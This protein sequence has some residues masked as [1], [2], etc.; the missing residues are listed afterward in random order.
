MQAHG[1]PLSP[2]KM[3]THILSAALLAALNIPATADVAPKDAYKAMLNVFAYDSQGKLLHSGAAFFTDAQGNAVTSYQMLQGASRAEV[4]DFKGK[5]YP[6]SRIL[7][8]NATTDLAK[9]SIEGYKGNEYFAI[10]GQ[11]A[12]KD[13]KL[14]LVRYTTD[15]KKLP[16]AVSI[17]SDEAYNAF[18]YYYVDAANE[19]ADMACPLIDETGSIVGIL[20]RNVKK[21]ASSAC[22]IDARFVH[23]LSIDATAAF[24]SDLR[25]IYIPKALPG[26]AKDALTYLYM[27]PASDSLACLTAYN[28]FVAAYPSMPDGYAGRALFHAEHRNFSAC[29]ADF[30]TALEKA[31][32]D[33]TG[34]K[35]DAVHHSLSNLIYD[36]TL[37]VA[38][39]LPVSEGLTPIYKDWN[40][41]RAEAEADLA[42]A[43]RPYSLYLLQKGKCQYAQGNYEGA[44]QSFS[45]VCEDK[46]FASPDTYLSAA[47][48]LE[49]TGRDSAQVIAL[50]DSCVSLLPKPA[51]AQYALYYWERAQRLIQAGRYRDAVLDFND[52]EVAVGPNNL[53]EE[54]YYIRSQTEMQARMYQQAIDDIRTAIATAADP[55]PYRLEEALILLR[56]GEYQQAIDAAKKLLADF[57][58][59]ADCHKI[60][61]IAYG[62]TGNKAQAVEHLKKAQATGDTTAA[63]LIEKYQ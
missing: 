22:A 62:E 8:A 20:Q 52:Y 15:K 55:L 50:L 13:S 34:M 14:Q 47:R 23:E 43:A 11:P 57:P 48:A 54:F 44:F 42:Y 4:I 5:K 26:N 32:A 18:R 39:S 51:T 12:A 19:P 16:Q 58:E 7:G 49:A 29:E 30:A 1:S 59:N 10:A 25:G 46:S 37:A 24:S 21:N 2:N 40:L 9:F 31:S 56:V 3:K 33:T 38:D 6:V 28:D 17:V 61:G 36:L 27:I 53:N 45:N 41:K 35:A 63:A 60:I